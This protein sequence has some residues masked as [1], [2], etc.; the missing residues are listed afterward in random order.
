MQ[1]LIEPSA[2]PLPRRRTQSILDAGDT[3]VELVVAVAI[4]GIAFAAILGGFATSVTASDFHQKQAQA[5]ALIHNFAE[6]LA[7]TD[8]TDPD[9]YQACT[10]AT[11]P[12]YPVPSTDAYPVGATP[13]TSLYQWTVSVQFWANAPTQPPMWSSTCP[14]TGDAGLQQVQI[15]VTTTDSRV[16]ESLTVLK[17]RA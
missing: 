12:N 3:L 15:T 7:S 4:L 11:L 1:G 13:A 16:S 5:E 2:V 17:R 6:H 10:A 9:A 14:A 8:T